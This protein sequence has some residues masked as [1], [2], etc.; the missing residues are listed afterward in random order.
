MSSF[1]PTVQVITTTDWLF[2]LL[3]LFASVVGGWSI[4]EIFLGL[5]QILLK[6]SGALKRIRNGVLVFVI[7][8]FI[9]FLLGNLLARTISE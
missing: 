2:V 9:F 5:V 8:V 1:V 4:I 6:R 7:N 3:G